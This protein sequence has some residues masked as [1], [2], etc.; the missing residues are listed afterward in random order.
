MHFG[1]IG[2]SNLP[3]QHCTSSTK[4]THHY[5][6]IVAGS[7]GLGKTT[8]LNNLIR[9]NIFTNSQFLDSKEDQSKQL[10]FFDSNGET[11]AKDYEIQENVIRFDGTEELKKT[12]FEEFKMTFEQT[13]TEIHERGINVV[14]SVLEIDRIGD[15]IDNED[16]HVPIVDFINKK[17]NEYFQKEQTIRRDAIRDE[18]VH[19]CLYFFEPAGHEI[20]EIDLK[21]MEEIS[22]VCVLIP[23]I[24][25]SD[26]YTL[27]EKELI[28]L[29]FLETTHERNIHFFQ[30]SKNF[31][32]FIVGNHI[33]EFGIIYERQYPWGAI[34]ANNKFMSD[35]EA[36][37]NLIIRDQLLEVLEESSLFYKKYRNN[38]L[39]EEV[40]SYLRYEDKLKI[41][42]IADFNRFLD[43]WASN[44]N[45]AAVLETK[46]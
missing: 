39:R 8:F 12:W 1:G 11:S 37:K 30:R 20:N 43:E 6:L 32:Y 40:M 26:M 27:E 46:Q 34:N 16:T 19:A 22:K 14:F 23:V 3:N 25:R 45:V 35:T 42:E 18:R 31:P 2:I 17:Y 29:N 4:K 10:Q 44:E 41:S 24:G 21:N 15:S 9:K 28:K 38:I 36:L 13:Q 33:D 7:K 5:N